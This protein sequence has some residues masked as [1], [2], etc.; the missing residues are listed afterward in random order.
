MKAFSSAVS[1]SLH[2]AIGAAV[3]FGTTR[4]AQSDPARPDTT[5]IVFPPENSLNAGEEMGRPL[6]GPIHFA[7]PDLNSL[8]GPTTIPEGT[9]PMQGFSPAFSPTGSGNNPTSG[10]SEVLTAEYAEVLAGP[11]PVYPDLLRQAGVQGR[12]VLEATIDTTGRVMATSIVVVV[13]TNPG[14]V[15]SARH[16]LLATLFRPA[17]VRGKSVRMRVR[18]PY[19]FAIRNGT[20]RAR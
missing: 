9:V 1:I 8:P 4:A 14:F 12:V 17:M 16:A 11:I 7:P 6:P 19:E 10:G 18:I 13:V 2:A 3:L 5:R 15:A 20:G